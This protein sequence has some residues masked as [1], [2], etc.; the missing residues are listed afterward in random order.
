MPDPISHDW[1]IPLLAARFA[2]GLLAGFARH[3]VARAGLASALQPISGII[4][5]LGDDGERDA[6]EC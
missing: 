3:Q 1:L 2:G 6:P 5:R 4:T